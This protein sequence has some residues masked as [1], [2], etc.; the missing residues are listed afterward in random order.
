MTSM[1]VCMVLVAL[2]QGW[3]RP[4]IEASELAAPGVAQMDTQAQ[5]TS[6]DLDSVTVP[7]VKEQEAKTRWE[8]DEEGKPVVR[9]EEQEPQ[10]AAK[11]IAAPKEKPVVK[12]D[13]R[14]EKNASGPIATF[15]L[16]MPRR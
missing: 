6:E 10:P 11:P 3:D 12:V 9:I 7:A 1:L 15:W 14:Q 5:T 8:Y 16:L 4:A 2:A 13:A